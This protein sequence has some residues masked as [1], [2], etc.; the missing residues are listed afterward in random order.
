MRE[1]IEGCNSGNLEQCWTW[2][3]L[4]ERF[5]THLFA[6]QYKAIH[7]DGSRYDDDVGGPLFVTGD[8]GTRQTGGRSCPRTPE[9]VLPC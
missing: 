6:D 5:G 3:Y 2:F 7:K 9:I 1:L 8:D 4:A